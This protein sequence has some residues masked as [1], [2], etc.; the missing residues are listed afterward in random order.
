MISATDSMLLAADGDGPGAGG[1][2]AELSGLA[3]WVAD[4]I[5]SLGSV[6]VGLLTLL[7][8]VFPPIP[9]EV[10]LPFAGYLA[11]LDRLNPVTALVAATIGSVAGSVVLYV[12]AEKLGRE[13]TDRLLT[14]VPL[15][16]TEDLDR[17]QGW[18]SEHGDAAVLIGR[19]IPGIRSVVSLP[20]GID[21][22][23]MWRFLVLTTIGSAVWNG[24]L[25]GAGY[26]LGRQWQD[27]GRYSGWLNWAVVVAI[28]AA[29]ARYV[30]NRRA[31]VAETVGS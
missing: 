9:S 3:G 13:R 7:E 30:W 28:V 15:V 14:K 5:E 6:G 20:A 18:F 12:V 22:M 8:V 27:L 4:V 29:V 1:G 17:A 26:A 16:S 25:I 19:C 24:A 2:A 10:V 31:R 21:R 23:P 11:A